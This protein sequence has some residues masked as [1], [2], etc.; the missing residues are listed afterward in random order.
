M[1]SVSNTALYETSTVTKYP[2]LIINIFFY[3]TSILYEIITLGIILR[4]LC[5]D[6]RSNSI[7]RMVGLHVTALAILGI[8]ALVVFGITIYETVNQVRYGYFYWST[9][10]VLLARKYIQLTY[11]ALYFLVA[12]YACSIS[13]YTLVRERIKVEENSFST[14]RHELTA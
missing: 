11:Q 2:Y 8:L 12:L 10:E 13:I 9:T 14:Q 3:L 6:T 4:T 7:R 5:E 1:L